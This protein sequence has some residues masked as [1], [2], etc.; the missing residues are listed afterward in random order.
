MEGWARTTGGRRVSADA[1]PEHHEWYIQQMGQTSRHV[2]LE[3]LAYL[4]TQDLS[5]KLPGIKTP[6]LAM[7]GE[8]SEGDIH[9]RAKGQADMMPN[10]T[11]VRVPG[12]SGYVQHSAP[13][14]CVQG[15]A[16]I[17]RHRA[18]DVLTTAG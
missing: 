13:E 14:K 3:T 11:L 1:A 17:H 12:A 2:V 10:C 4:A 8:L 16:G 6:A 5:S 15:L 9:D 7:V 18:Q